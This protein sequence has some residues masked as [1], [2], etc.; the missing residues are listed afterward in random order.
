[1]ARSHGKRT[2][3]KRAKVIGRSPGRGPGPVV[4]PLLV[5][6]SQSGPARLLGDLKAEGRLC[7]PCPPRGGGRGSSLPPPS[8][9]ASGRGVRPAGTGRGSLPRQIVAGLT[10]RGKGKGTPVGLGRRL[11]RGRRL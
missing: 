7:P 2:S 6:H 10:A 1:L 9:H 3:R 11:P 5:Q 4:G 8:R